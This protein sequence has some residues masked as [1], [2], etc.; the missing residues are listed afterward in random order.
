MHLKVSK[1][2]KDL[3]LKT[4]HLTLGLL[5]SVFCCAQQLPQT[6]TV[7]A[8]NTRFAVFAKNIEGSTGL[9]FYYNPVELDSFFVTIAARQQPLSTVLETVFKNTEFRFSADQ[10][11]RVFVTKKIGIQTALPEYITRREKITD[12][13]INNIELNS[14]LEKSDDNL[15]Q[16]TVI[17]FGRAGKSG[18]AVLS[19]FVK[20]KL[21][22]EP[23]EGATITLGN[24]TVSTNAVG[25]YR[26]QIPT[27]K[28]T[29]EIT[30]IGLTDFVRD[31]HLYA[32][33]ELN[34]ELEDRV[35]ILKTITI[36]S[37]RRAN[38]VKNLE[39]GVEKL[40]IKTI[41]QMPVVFGQADV[42]RAVMALPG[43]TSVGEA[44]TGFNVR[45]GA[46]DQNLIL[47][48]D[49]TIYN[50][51][52][53][54]GFFSAFNPEI[55]RGIE[56]YKSSIPEK[57][58][59]RLSSVL[60]VQ[61]K[62]GNKKKFSGAG[63]ISP[64]TSH[65]MAE[66]PIVKEKS[67]LLAAVR[68]TYSD[69]LLNVIP[70]KE[71]RGSKAGFYDVSLHYSNQL[72]KKDFINVTGYISN[73][74][75]RLGYDTTYKYGNRNV[76]F[77]WKRNLENNLLGVFTAGYDGYTY[78]IDSDRNPV[79]AYKLKFN[80]H[81]F[82]GRADFTKTYGSI[83]KLSYGANVV[84][85]NLQ[86]GSFEPNHE[87][88]L[89]VK[90]TVQ[91]EN[92]LEAALYIGDEWKITDK[93]SVSGGL[94][95]S[96]FLAMGAKTVMK[97]APG[98]PLETYNIVDSVK[99][100]NMQVEK[101]YHGPELR[102]SARYILGQSL[103]LKVGYNSLRQ[104]IHMLSN[105]TAISP[106]DIWKLSDTHI[107]PQVGQQ[108]SLGLY[109]IFT[110]SEVEMSLEGYYK[111]IKNYLDYK[112][113][114]TLVMNKNI[115]TDVV[116]SLGEAYGVEF[117]LKR[118][119]GRLNGWISYTYS[120][121]MLKTDDPLAAQPVNQGKYYPANIDKPHAVNLISN[122]RFTHR[123]STS[124]NGVYSTGRPITVPIAVFTTGG[125]ERVLYSERNQYRVPDVF[126]LDFS[127][128]IEGNHKIKKLAHSSWTIGVYNI[129]GR[130]N[131]YSVFFKTENGAIKGYR[132]SIFGSQIP[133]VTYNFKF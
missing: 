65:L 127:M 121:T 55:V 19:G 124:I 98:M 89:V 24:K 22:A 106:T 27:G 56:L 33:G 69:W 58:G 31:I 64:V 77:K 48:N 74:K 101:P 110:D 87:Q 60:E 46:S 107:K 36:E 9:K 79:N 104:Y 83:H 8:E 25:F 125:A 17:T 67:S 41:K 39:M 117:L 2:K 99:Y 4:Q 73:D 88:S 51:A 16:N 80:I 90:N 132:L 49:A 120:K 47:M 100:R 23:I 63:G 26:I 129:T 113:G 108:V 43:V 128:N 62:E 109:K 7:N 52:H 96:L 29:L 122:F 111:T 14:L 126:R 133:F 38:V 6:I 32:N 34:V 91:N 130:K 57:Y 75:F 28:Y 116:K 118:N 10:W 45:G 103:S 76:N 95:Y 119:K 35:V 93:L 3:L 42:I 81:Q 54:F 78:N 72:N 70:N 21:N 59:G 53:F 82:F 61:L 66:I 112:S 13:T 131:P 12:T 50:P 5:I 114:A 37:S 102:F 97:Y 123:F 44:S 94:R 86:P 68:S 15:Q 84:T 105:T 92:A 30:S 115:E 71:F 1:R 18:A 20:N 85:Y 11:N 40:N